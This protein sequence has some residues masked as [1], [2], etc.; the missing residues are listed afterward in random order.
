[1]TTPDIIRLYSVSQ[2]IK[3]NTFYS[4]ELLWPLS[5]LRLIERGVDISRQRVQR[6]L[7]E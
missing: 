1:M 5:N 6:E 2:N 4:P 7:V 3:S